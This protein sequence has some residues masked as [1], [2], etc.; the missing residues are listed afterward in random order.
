VLVDP[1]DATQLADSLVALGCL[2]A[3]QLDING[4]WPSFVT[5][6][7]SATGTGAQSVDKRMTGNPRRFLDGSSKEF[8]AFFDAAAVPAGSVLDR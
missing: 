7:H 8:F 2:E 5:Y 6:T 3:M 1:V 4:Q